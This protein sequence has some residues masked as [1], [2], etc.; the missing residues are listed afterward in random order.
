V[1]DKVIRGFKDPC[2]NGEKIDIGGEKN[3]NQK[4]KESLKG[5]MQMQIFL[6]VDAS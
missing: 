4:N 5:N 2:V 3:E 6:R 1:V